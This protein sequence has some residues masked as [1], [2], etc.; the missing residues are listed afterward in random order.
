MFSLHYSFSLKPNFLKCL[1]NIS[2]SKASCDYL[3]CP[4]RYIKDDVSMYSTK[5]NGN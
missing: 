2:L 4:Y 5:G 1:S 3:F